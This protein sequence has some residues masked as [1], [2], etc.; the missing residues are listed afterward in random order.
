ML[1][2]LFLLPPSLKIF[3]T[4]HLDFSILEIYLL[5]SIENEDLALPCH[6]PQPPTNTCTLFLGLHLPK[7]RNF[8]WL[9]IISL[10]RCCKL[11]SWLALHRTITAFRFLLF[12][13][14]MAMRNLL[15]THSFV[16]TVSFS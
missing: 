16:K 10:L 9:R 2:F 1:C 7:S 13:T 8:H 11:Y 15:S 12:Q 3:I 14:L 6:Q 4:L 5:V